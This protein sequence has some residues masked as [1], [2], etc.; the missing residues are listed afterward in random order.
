MHRQ[1]VPRSRA[2]T[3]RDRRLLAA[4]GA[5]IRARRRELGR[6]IE[7]VAIAAELSR[8]YLSEIETGT[9]APSLMML[10]AIAHELGVAVW[11]LL[12]PADSGEQ[13]ATTDQGSA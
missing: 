9:K 1:A 7:D 11:L 2:Q 13:A 3:D 6:S 5:N 12:Q 8:N 4:V 10:G